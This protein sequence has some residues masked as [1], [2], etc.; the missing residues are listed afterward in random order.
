MPRPRLTEPPA[1]PV[2][3]SWRRRPSDP[4][5]IAY[6]L[7]T[8]GNGENGDGADLWRRV[9][10]RTG[11]RVFHRV[12]RRPWIPETDDRAPMSGW[13]EVRAVAAP[14]SPSIPEA[15]Q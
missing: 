2:N 1:P 14:P 15:T 12:C 6:A 9:E 10:D 13:R 7:D 11:P 3:A 8:T 5:T 4:P